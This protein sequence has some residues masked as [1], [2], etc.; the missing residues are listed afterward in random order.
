[1]ASIKCPECGNEIIQKIILVKM[2]SDKK[3][4]VNGF[5]TLKKYE[6][7]IEAAI[8]KFNAT[9]N[10]ETI[11]YDISN[12]QIERDVIGNLHNSM[13]LIGFKYSENCHLPDIQ[14]YMV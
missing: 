13:E 5:F 8:S 10:Y 1:M 4:R 3:Y 7:E 14:D 12:G 11:L 9:T 6:K 2:P